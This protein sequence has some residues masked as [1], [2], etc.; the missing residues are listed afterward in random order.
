MTAALHVKCDQCHHEWDMVSPF[1]PAM[2]PVC[3]C[4]FCGH[5]GEVAV[6]SRVEFP[7]TDPLRETL[8]GDA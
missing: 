6:L 5:R 8:A 7:T 3:A 2:R 1:G 4:S